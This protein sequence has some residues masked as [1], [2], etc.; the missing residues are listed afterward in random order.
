LSEARFPP[1]GAVRAAPDPAR[2][3]GQPRRGEPGPNRFDDPEGIFV[4]RYL[5]D[6]LRG[7]LIELLSRFRRNEEAEAR[8]AAITGTDEEGAHPGAEALAEWFARQRVARCHLVEPAG[9]LV[10]VNDPKLLVDLDAELRVRAVLGV[11][12]LGTPEDPARLDE[13]TIRLKGPVGRRITQAVSRVLYERERRPAGLA[14]RSRLDDAERCW[15]LYG[16]TEVRFEASVALS[17]EDESQL[18]VVR[19]V[20]TLYNLP[21]PTPWKVG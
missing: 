12:G 14:Y 5:A 16:E 17:A 3:P 1:G 2:L 11:S 6:S 7:C 4:V 9:T 13:G 18:E 10:D 21:L 8:I 15:A 20:A 19:A